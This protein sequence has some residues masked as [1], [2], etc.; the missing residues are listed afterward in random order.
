VQVDSVQ[1]DGL[2]FSSLPGKLDILFN[3]V[4]S[5]MPSSLR[6]NQ[7]DL[8]LDWL[9]EEHSSIFAGLHSKLHSKSSS[10]KEGAVTVAK[11]NEDTLQ[12]VSPR[13]K[14]KITQYES[15]VTQIA[16]IY[17]D[18]L[19][20]GNALT[21]TGHI[22]DMD[23]E[24]RTVDT[25]DHKIK[26]YVKKR[27]LNCTIVDSSNAAARLDCW[28]DLADTVHTQLHHE[29]ADAPVAICFTFLAASK[30]D[31]S[32]RPYKKL[33]ATKKTTFSNANPVLPDQ[34]GEL[35][36][37]KLY[38]SFFD[39]LIVAMPYVAN[40]R[41]IVAACETTISADGTEMKHFELVDTKGNSVEMTAFGRHGGNALLS[42]GNEVIIFIVTALIKDGAPHGHLWVYD[43][44]HVVLRRANATVP[45]NRKLIH[46]VR[47]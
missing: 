5:K 26:A 30:E 45:Q 14:S 44:A 15:R 32:V 23:D 36:P 24:P 7:N 39:E 4:L 9:L 10:S 11:S 47:K 35:I 22:V 6:K 42:S 34:S 2:D 40:V 41:G 46:L 25:M 13:K 3:E 8:K 28:G 33:S 38:V 20:G 37:E 43:K 18:D 16:G 17:A 27:V 21:I 19:E 12:F 31:K 29:V 1:L